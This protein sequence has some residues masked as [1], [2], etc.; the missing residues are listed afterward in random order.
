[1]SVQFPAKKGNEAEVVEK[2]NKKIKPNLDLE[3]TAIDIER[4]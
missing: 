2:K 1:L 3:G 4:R